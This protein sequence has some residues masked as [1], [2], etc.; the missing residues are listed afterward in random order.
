MA[1]GTSSTRGPLRRWT[2]EAVEQELQE[3][4]EQLG[5]RPA[6]RDYDRHGRSTLARAMSRHGGRLSY[7]HLVAHLP[8]APPD[9]DAPPSVGGYWNDQTVQRELEDY[10]RG[11][12]SFP[13]SAQMDG[14]GRSALRVAISH[15]GGIGRWS[16]ELGLPLGPKQ[17]QGGYGQ[18]EAIRDAQQLIGSHGRLPGK[19]RVREL[20]YPRLAT[21][22]AVHTDGSNAF[23]VQHHD[24]LGVAPS[25]VAKA[26]RALAFR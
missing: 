17:A 18:A 13:T 11:M 15:R 12:T 6:G 3:F 24:Q 20:G 21:Y 26:R 9:P 16:H 2:R 23:L 5:H 10:T 19:T 7:R 22:L 25:V 4:A 14:D 1:S 8:P